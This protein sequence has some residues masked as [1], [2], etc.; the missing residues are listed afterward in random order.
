[1]LWFGYDPR[2]GTDQFTERVAWFMD[3]GVERHLALD[4]I[5]WCS[6]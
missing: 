4:G 6:S 2:P 3:G 1:M 5:S